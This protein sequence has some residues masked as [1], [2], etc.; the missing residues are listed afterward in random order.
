MADKSG[1]NQVTARTKNS[2]A[3]RLKLALRENLKRRKTQ[4]RERG[5]GPSTG[6]KISLHEAGG[7]DPDA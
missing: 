5:K 1:K 3:S 7:D 2:R 4:A 6:E